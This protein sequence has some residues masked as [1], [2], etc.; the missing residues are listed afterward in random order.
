[1]L[2]KDSEKIQTLRAIFK[3]HQSHCLHCAGYNGATGELWRL[4]YQGMLQFKAILDVADKVSE[5]TRD[6]RK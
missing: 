6:N 1:M 5:Q 4:C 2:V 3:A